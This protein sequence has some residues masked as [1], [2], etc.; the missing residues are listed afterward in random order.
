MR[1]FRLVIVLTAS[2]VTFLFV[3]PS[4]FSPATV[5]AEA[6]IAGVADASPPADVHMPDASSGH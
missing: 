1:L 3:A 4:T 5:R 2:I 6:S